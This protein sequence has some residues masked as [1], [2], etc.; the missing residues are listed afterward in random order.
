MS[1]LN[2]PKLE[3]LLDALH[4][5]SEGQSDAMAEY[6]GRRAREG[7]LDWKRM[8]DET[9]RFFRDKMVALEKDKAEYCYALCRALRATRVV[10][11]GT[12]F[13]V[14]TLYL[15]AA[16]R[17]NGGGTVI[18]TEY[19]PTKARIARAN[20]AAANLS[21]YIDLREGDLAETLKVIDGPVDL[22]L[23]D[24]WTDAVMPAVRNVAPHLREGAIILADNSAQSRDGY[25]QY[26]EYIADPRNRLRTLTL[27]F[28]GGLE[29]T[30]RV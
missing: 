19:E 16:V 13:G 26:F 3:T 21:D 25:A 20:F 17:D 9:H 12:S 4:A 8:D 2:D 22:M 1:I 10:E 28:A 15:A 24:I 7:T 5:Q 27:P 18:A 30:V 29:M 11:A 23:L 14:S 6:F